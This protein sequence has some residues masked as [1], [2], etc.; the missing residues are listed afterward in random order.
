MSSESRTPVRSHWTFTDDQITSCVLITVLGSSSRY[1]RAPPGTYMH[2]DRK[3]QDISHDQG[4][5]NGSVDEPYRS[6]ALKVI[7]IILM[8]IPPMTW[9]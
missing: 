3:F 6:L 1:V 9:L 2:A 7:W 4:P 8:S 5:R